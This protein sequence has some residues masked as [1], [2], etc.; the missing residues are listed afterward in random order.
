MA[1]IALTTVLVDLI[2]NAPYLLIE[3]LD[4]ELLLSSHRTI[5]A[6]YVIPGLGVLKTILSRT[7]IVDTRIWHSTTIRN[8]VNRNIWD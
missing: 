1:T 6:D 3:H 8:N 4:K 2:F 5:G 7:R